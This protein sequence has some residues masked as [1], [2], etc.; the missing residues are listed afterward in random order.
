MPENVADP[1]APR[2][3][4]LFSRA[5][6]QES[7]QFGP[8]PSLPRARPARGFA[9]A[10]SIPTSPGPDVGCVPSGDEGP[11]DPLIPDGSRRH[12]PVDAAHAE[13]FDFEEFLDAV[14]RA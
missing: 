5:R 1:R 4:R 9:K 14:F 3:Y 13:V 8:D 10:I 12:L 2:C 7:Q 11:E 6:V